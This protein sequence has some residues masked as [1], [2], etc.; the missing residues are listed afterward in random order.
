M[1]L[2]ADSKQLHQD[3]KFQ[4][5]WNQFPKLHLMVNFVTLDSKI[6]IVETS[7]ILDA[8]VYYLLRCRCWL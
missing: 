8:H 3:L 7:T 1:S 2:S 6:R 4:A 5:Q